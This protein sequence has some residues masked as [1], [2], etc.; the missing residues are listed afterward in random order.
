MSMTNPVKNFDTAFHNNT[1]SHT[2][3]E[4]FNQSLKNSGI[5]LDDMVPILGEARWPR[6]LA[7]VTKAMTVGP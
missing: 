1:N 6:N 4:S 3:V 5:T 7:E 2:I